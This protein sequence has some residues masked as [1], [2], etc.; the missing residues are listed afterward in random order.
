VLAIDILVFAL[1]A[2]S[3]H[4]IMGPGGLISFGHAAFFGLGAY[5]A[6]LL[7]KKAGLPMEVALALGPVIAA[8]GAAVVGAFG[9][10]LSG[11]YLA[12]LTLAFAQIVWSVVFQ[13]DAFTGGSNGLV[14]IWPSAWLSG[15]TA[16]YVLTAALCVGGM[17][18]LRRLAFSP[19]GYALRAGRDSPLRAEAIGIDVARVQ[20]AGFVV[21]G[22][23]AG[24][25]GAVQAFSK[26]SIAPETLSVQRSVGALVMVLAGGLQSLSGPVVGAALLTWL[27]DLIARQFDYWRLLLGLVIIGIVL[28][29]PQGIVGQ[30]LA[31]RRARVEAR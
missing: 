13:W 10:R 27:Q 25:A 11:V 17:L 28:G 2:A 21:A 9:M 14:G 8:I 18:V 19:F 30:I 15:D 20:W 5:G 26:G 16:F 23:F 12:M 7:L 4:F 6:G 24:L 22:L 29:F 1:F 31:W 3:L